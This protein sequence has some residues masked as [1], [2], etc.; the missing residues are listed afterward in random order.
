MRCYHAEENIGR[1]LK[2]VAPA[3]ALREVEKILTD[4]EENAYFTLGTKHLMF[5][6]GDATWSPAAGRGIPRLAAGGARQ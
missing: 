4:S 6:I 3:P 5:R 1:K 2:F